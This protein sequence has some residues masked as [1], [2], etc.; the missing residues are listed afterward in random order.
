MHSIEKIADYITA[1]TIIGD[2]SLIIKGLCGID[3]GK[4]DYISYIHDPQYIKY[5]TVTKASAIIVNNSDL[6]IFTKNETES[7]N[8]YNDKT[9]I[10]VHNAAQAF[11]KLI[12][13]FTDKSD[14][15]HT[16][17]SSAIISDKSKLGSNCHIGHNTIID[18][19][20][21]IGNDVF[22]GNGCYIGNNSIIDNKSYLSNNVTVVKNSKIG[23][24]VRVNSGTVIGGSGFG[25]FTNDKKHFP[26]PHI[27]DVIIGNNVS[28]GSNCCIDRGTINNT[29][30]GDNTQID[31]LV[32]VA[33]NVKIG[34][35]CIIAGQTGIAG[36]A[37]VGNFVTMGGQVGIVG[38]IEIS[39]NVTIAGKSL[40][41]KSIFENE[42]ISGIPAKNHKKRIKQEATI[43]RLPKLFKNIKQ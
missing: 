29:S 13:L 9:L 34:K 26:I 1:T 7:I 21:V 22:I 35:G 38:H 42:L 24:N 31:N 16:I 2:S 12:Y 32:Q 30:I 5:L 41:T 27:G 20:V 25:L 10:A 14:V 8:N 19:N 37:I 40:V 17:N 15:E 3:N 18:D 43:N 28:I 4:A 23:E 33:H 36:S 11:S 39:N 6:S